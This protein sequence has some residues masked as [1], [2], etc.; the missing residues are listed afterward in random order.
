ML[1]KYKD[2]STRHHE[3]IKRGVKGDNEDKKRGF[4]HIH[5]Q[6]DPQHLTLQ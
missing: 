2:E 5:P 4:Q 1:H 6:P 3:G